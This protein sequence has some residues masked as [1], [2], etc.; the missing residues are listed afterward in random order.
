[1]QK[2]MTYSKPASNAGEILA[3]ISTPNSKPFYDAMLSFLT[4]EY[5]SVVSFGQSAII[6]L[7]QIPSEVKADCYADVIRV[8]DGLVQAGLAK[9]RTTMVVQ[10]ENEILVGSRVDYALMD[11]E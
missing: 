11:R 7:N 2:K 10:G 9:S 4:S 1:M 6:A 3:L 5:Q 8:L